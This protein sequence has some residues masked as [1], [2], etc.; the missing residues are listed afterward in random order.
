[1]EQSSKS[2]SPSSKS[3]G[4]DVSTMEDLHRVL[5]NLFA[6]GDSKK[7]EAL[8]DALSGE[9]DIDAILAELNRVDGAP[10]RFQL[11]QTQRAA[12]K[13]LLTE[14]R[15][16][17]LSPAGSS[18]ASRAATR[19][20]RELLSRSP[21]EVKDFHH[22]VVDLAADL[23]NPAKWETVLATLRKYAPDEQWTKAHVE[24]LIA[25]NAEGV[26]FKS[27]AWFP[28]IGDIW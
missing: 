4:R 28:Y 1:M 21:G 16:A 5:R 2:S 10:R 24:A 9:G 6:E 17:A 14:S 27:L 26:R 20:W 13:A 25:V 12:L 19:F 15:Y 11:N 18:P 8:R 7:A 3:A 22:Q 23:N